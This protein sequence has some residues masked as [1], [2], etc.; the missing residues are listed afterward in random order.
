MSKQNDNVYVGH[1]MDMCRIVRMLVTGASRADLETDIKLQL[2][3]VRA[4]STIGEAARNVSAPY[5][6][7]HPGIRWSAIIAMRHK[8]VHDYFEIDYD[9]VWDAAVRDVP[10]LLISLERLELRP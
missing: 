7:A 3:L 10:E 4:I 8:L 9:V 5:C 6:E 1:M 2:A